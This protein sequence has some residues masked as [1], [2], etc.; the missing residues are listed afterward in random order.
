MFRNREGL[1]DRVAL[2][3]G[4]RRPKDVTE[5]DPYTAMRSIKPRGSD[6]EIAVPVRSTAGKAIWR[7]VASLRHQTS[8]KHETHILESLTDRPGH[9]RLVAGWVLA[10]HRPDN[11]KD[12]GWDI[13][14][15]SRAG[16]CDG[17][18]E[19]SVGR[20]VGFADT[21]AKE[22]W[23][24]LKLFLVTVGCE[25]SPQKSRLVR[26]EREF[27][28]TAETTYRHIIDRPDDT[29]AAVTSI[30]NA[31]VAAYE[32]AAGGVGNT[33]AARHRNKPDTASV[34]VP[35]AATREHHRHA[36]ITALRKHADS[37]QNEPDTN[38]T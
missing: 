29:E 23:K 33:T 5:T 32:T 28:A 8:S 27:W 11:A 7:D 4:R 24:Q 1:V 25:Q 38:G 10:A 12:K 26:A 19:E 20:L 14:M 6:I 15:I 2:A 30:R 34:V 13:S 36:L 21:A 35:V 37:T 16:L 17:A 9:L 22:L 31:A 3:T 18:V